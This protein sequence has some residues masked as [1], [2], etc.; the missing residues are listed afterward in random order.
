MTAAPTG[1]GPPFGPDRAAMRAHLEKLFERARVEYPDGLCE[2]AWSSKDLEKINSA[3][4]FAITPEGLVQAADLAFAK[5]SDG[6][7]VYVGVN[8]RKP[9]TE[10]FGRAED[11]DVEIAFVHV[12]DLDGADVREAL[13]ASALPHTFNVVTGL[14]PHPRVHAYWALEEPTWNMRAWKAQQL[15]IGA[16]LH[17]DDISNPSR[18]VRLAGSVNWPKRNKVKRHY[19]AELTTLRAKYAGGE[20]DPVSSEALRQAFPPSVNGAANDYAHTP[21]DD[22]EIY[23]EFGLGVLDLAKLLARIRA[24]RGGW[25][26]DVRTLVD[27]LIGRGTPDSI[28]LALAPSITLSPYTLADT[29][30][31]L[32]TLITRRRQK[33][34]NPNDEGMLAAD[35]ASTLGILDHCAWQLGEE[36]E[37]PWL[38]HEVIPEHE[39]SMIQGDGGM[40]KSKLALQLLVSTSLSQTHQGSDKPPVSWV[41]EK[42]APSRA[43]GVFCEDDAGELQRRLADVC[44]Y[45]EITPANLTDLLLICQEGRDNVLARFDQKGVMR[46][47]DLLKTLTAKVKEFGGG[48]PVTVVLD[49]KADIFAGNVISISD[50]KAFVA[51][52]YRYL[53]QQA[54]ATVIILDHPSLTGMTTGTGTGGTLQ[55][56]N[57]VRARLYL[58]TQKGEEGAE[59]DYSM[60]TLKVMKENYGPIGREIELQWEHGVFVSTAEPP[61]DHNG[62]MNELVRKER[63]EG[64][65]LELLRKTN[66]EKRPVSH[67]PQAP[68]YAPK[69]FAKRPDRY[70]YRRQD[71]EGAMERLFSGRRIENVEYGP[72]SK[73]V[74]RIVERGDATEPK[75]Y[76][77]L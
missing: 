18:I 9:D 8:P 22:P 44:R 48:L 77:A 61:A 25:H 7:N 54:N 15:A 58:T 16:A 73:R 68:T 74:S 64:V 13:N 56:N 57:A 75:E 59:P 23:D 32:R 35:A 27:H 60:R 38:V 10:P 4:L 41:G 63:V 69:A 65:F 3:N 31:E 17:G 26:N 37:Q 20:R 19:I 5:N 40:G 24:G 47:T 12:A 45:H 33:T 67:K 14:Q 51:L 76:S 28:I 6:L 2:I 62:A 72:P 43:V 39:V 36:P 53:C 70:G 71:F 55:W 46:A 42:L 21:P 1:D 11:V 52:L 50:A 29:E 34:D 66:A 49:A 30:R